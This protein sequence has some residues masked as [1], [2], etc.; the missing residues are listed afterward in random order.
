MKLEE[1]IKRERVAS[2]GW[3]TRAKKLEVNL[4]NLSSIPVEKKS[5]KKLIEEKYK[6]IEILQ[7][8]L[9]GIPSDHP[10][11]QEIIAIQAEKE[12]LSNEVLE[13][14]TK[15]LQVNKENEDLIKEKEDLISQ[16]VSY[17]PWQFHSL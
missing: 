2:K 7:K 3:K 16:R 14:K 6:L 15:L 8:K 11:T 12:Q 10:Q 17:E 9:K 13:L 1:Q 5:N 4:V